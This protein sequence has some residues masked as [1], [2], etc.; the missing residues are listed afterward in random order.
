LTLR[1]QA[2]F[3]G[4]TTGIAAL[5]VSVGVAILNYRLYDIDRI[6]CRTLAYAI[7]TRL[8]VGLRGGRAAGHQG[9]AGPCAGGDGRLHAGGGT[10][11][12]AAAA[13]EADRRQAVP[14]VT[15]A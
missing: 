5:P 15:L 12:P 13:G 7:L 2:V 11:L 6:S 4:A 14:A 3:N 10:V 9:V 1:H 8:L